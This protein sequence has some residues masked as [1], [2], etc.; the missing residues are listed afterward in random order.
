LPGVAVGLAFDV[1]F[2]MSAYASIPCENGVTVAENVTCKRSARYGNLSPRAVLDYRIAPGVLLFAG[3]SRG[4]KA[5]GFTATQ[6]GSTFRNELV[7]NYEAG[8]K[9]DVR[10]LGLVMNL[11][12]FHYAANN[13]QTLR[14]ETPAGSLVS[15]VTD[16]SDEQA[17]ARISTRTGRPARFRSASMPKAST[18]MPPIVAG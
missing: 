7:D 4:Y 12:G 18:S 3:F 11:S 13:R 1:I 6:P 15:R 10:K 2:D 17:W 5:G 16:T 9:A 14:L 8:I